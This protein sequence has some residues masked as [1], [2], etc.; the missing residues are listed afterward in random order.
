[1]HVVDRID[2][3]QIPGDCLE[4]CKTPWGARRWRIQLQLTVDR[5]NAIA[6]LRHVGGWTPE[7]LDAAPD[8]DLAEVV[9]MLAC[10]SLATGQ[11]S[12]LLLK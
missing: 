12:F 10:S 4:S 2:K 1:M 11:E 5:D 8:E 7:T 6:Y 9:L 3:T